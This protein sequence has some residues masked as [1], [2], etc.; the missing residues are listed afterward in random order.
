MSSWNFISKPD[1][2]GNS[3]IQVIA[4]EDDMSGAISGSAIFRGVTFSI[5]GQ[6]VAKGSV[7]GRNDSVFWLGG[8]TT[9]DPAPTLFS[10]IGELNIG[11]SPQ[12]MT[13]N[14][15][16]IG[17]ADGRVMV[18]SDTLVGSAPPDDDGD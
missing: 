16:S 14:V 13:I 1:A 9:T 18:Q 6:W 11:V 5:S 7:P 2:G 8:S 15:T 17:S 12:I 3:E 10:A 4:S